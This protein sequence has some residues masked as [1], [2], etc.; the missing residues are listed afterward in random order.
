[1]FPKQ[2]VHTIFI[3]FFYSNFSLKISINLFQFQ[4]EMDDYFISD[5]FYSYFPSLNN[6]EQE[7]KQKLLQ[8]RNLEY[9]EYLKHVSNLKDSVKDFF[10]TLKFVFKDP[11]TINGQIETKTDSGE[12]DRQIS[13]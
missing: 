9:Q 4:N 2:K 13:K 11:R 12:S 8:Q 7:K 5:Q 3:T 10:V 6:N 1:M